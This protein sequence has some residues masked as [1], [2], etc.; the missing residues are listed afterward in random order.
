[1]TGARRLPRQPDHN[2]V[3]PGDAIGIAI[4]IPVEHLRT[5]ADLLS[6]HVPPGRIADQSNF[7]TVYPTIGLDT[8]NGRRVT[9]RWVNVLG[10][11]PPSVAPE[12]G[13]GGLAFIGAPSTP[14]SRLWRRQGLA[15]VPGRMGLALDRHAMRA[16]IWIRTDGGTLAA[17]ARFDRNGEP[18]TALPQH[19][20]LMDPARPVVWTGDEWG[21]R[22]DGIG[23]VEFQGSRGRDSFDAYI[24]LDLDLGWDYRFEA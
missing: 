7:V 20:Y 17:T 13:V 19:Y 14:I 10:V 21:T 5:L 16:R 2:R 22:F 8:L 18:W 24:G 3:E 9:H 15:F 11:P 6:P 12:D 1:M 23:E 4:R